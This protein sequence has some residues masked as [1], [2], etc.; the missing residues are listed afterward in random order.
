MVLDL[1]RVISVLELGVSDI[2]GVCEVGESHAA[3]AI[4][5]NGEVA[6]TKI[7]AASGRSHEVARSNKKMAPKR[8]SSPRGM[9]F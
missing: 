6:W 5:E 9:T 7:P 4:E 1:H 2:H 8:K 3:R